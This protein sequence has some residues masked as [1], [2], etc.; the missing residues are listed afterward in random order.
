MLRLDAPEHVDRP[1][2]ERVA[3]PGGPT[4]ASPGPAIDL[5]AFRAAVALVLLPVVVAT[6]RALAGGWLPVGDNAYF[7]I[8]ARDVLTEHHPLLGTWTSASISAGAN[9]N[10]PGPLLF[11]LF[12]G[13]ARLFDGG[14][15]VAVGAALLNCLAIV[16]IAVVAR[17]RGGPV[18]G[19]LAMVVTAGLTWSMGSELLFDPW[20]PHSLLLTSLLLVVLVWSLAC[21]DVVALPW[22]AGVASLIVQTHLSYAAIVAALGLW[23]VAGLIVSLR[24]HRRDQPQTWSR[25]R[26]TALRSTAAAGVVVALCWAQPLAEQVAGEGDGNLTRLAGNAG[27]SPDTVGPALGA[28]VVA[29][30]VATPPGYLRPSFGDAL[31]P[32]EDGGSVISG[33]RLPDLPSTGTAAVALAVLGVAL[34]GC[35]VVA[36]RR[37][38]RTAVAGVVTAGVALLAGLATASSL[39]L[40]FVGIAPHQF[41]WL[42]PLSAFVVLAVGAVVVRSSSVGRGR[43]AVAVAGATV[44]LV[45]A[46]ATLPSYNVGAGPADDDWAIPVVRDLNRAMA[47]LEGEGPLLI[48]MRG[49]RFAEPYSGPVMAELQRRDIPFVVDDEGMV[50]Q[51]GPSRR[52]EPGTPRL[53]IRE[54]DATQVTPP[55]ERRVVLVEGLDGAEQEELDDVRSAVLAHLEDLGRVPLAP[56]G[57]AALARGDLPV[58]AARPEVLTVDPAALLATRELDFMVER[59][60][61]DLDGA[62]RARFARYAE[63]QRAWDYETVALFIAPPDAGP[64]GG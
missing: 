62:W 28:R 8:R 14:A 50:R 24:R 58:A 27:S 57:E 12:A 60:L 9:F 36:G 13:P 38:D 4:D 45:A 20:Q 56:R 15:G 49:I 39:P 1:E 53:L 37:R 11:D 54:G 16:G 34:V 44:V 10:N 7:A 19:V 6:A 63:L 33:V 32:S 21:G 35:G 41:R 51:L 3:A 17:R 64:A 29:A 46:I 22:A 52:A 55:G 59:D 31:R 30:V 18:L 25:A 26:R 48:D 42:W 40:G 47:V 23:G 2:P 43:R 61:L 5:W